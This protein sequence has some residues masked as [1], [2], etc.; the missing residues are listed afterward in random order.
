V[1]P[2]NQWTTSAF[3]LCGVVFVVTSIIAVYVSKVGWEDWGVFM[4]AFAAMYYSGGLRWMPWKTPT[5][6]AFSL[7]VFVGVSATTIEWLYSLH[8]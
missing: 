2:E 6:K 5:R 8:Q 4:I 7:G 3:I 1:A